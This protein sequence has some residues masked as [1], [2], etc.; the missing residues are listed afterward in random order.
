MKQ[1]AK[2]E[3]N[4]CLISSG[5][6]ESEKNIVTHEFNRIE[7]KKRKYLGKTFGFQRNFMP[8]RG[9]CVLRLYFHASLDHTV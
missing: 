9:D 7:D 3:S 4:D 5:I 6:L 2:E 1:E 8:T